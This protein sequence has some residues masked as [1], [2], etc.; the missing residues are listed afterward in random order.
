MGRGGMRYGAGRPGW[1]CKAESCLRLDVRELARRGQLRGGH[2]GWHWTNTATGERS[3]SVA[4]WV[5]QH[6][7]VLTYSTDGTPVA[8]TIGLERTPCPFG[9]SRPWLRCGRCHRR[10]ALIYFGGTNFSCRRCSRVAYSSQSEDAIDRAWRRQA[11]LECRLGPDGSRP[12]GMRLATYDRI[13]DGI[14]ACEDR[15]DLGLAAF[16][17]RAGL[18]DAL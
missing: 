1:R 4:G 12:K 15:R 14:S 7:L 2:F 11:K 3:G 13:L 18:L 10:V 5:E 16:L 9:G 17:L 8:Q 6:A